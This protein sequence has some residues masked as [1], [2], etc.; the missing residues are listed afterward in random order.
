MS[1]P[2]LPI[3][4]FFDFHKTTISTLMTLLDPFGVLLHFPALSKEKAMAPHSRT[5]ACKIPWTE[6]PGRLPSMGSHRVGHD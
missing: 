5:L 1:H 4:Q 3:S 6:K 2:S